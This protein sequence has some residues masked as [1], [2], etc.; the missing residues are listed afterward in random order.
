MFLSKYTT[1][2]A[3]ATDEQIREIKRLFRKSMHGVV[4]ASMREKGMAYRVNF[5]LTLPLIKRIASSITPNEI[6]AERLWKEHVRES[7]MLA[8]WLYPPQK[9]DMSTAKRWIDETPY[10]EIADV[11]CMN[12]FPYIDD[13]P[14]QATDCIASSTDMTRYKGNQH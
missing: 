14:Q 9:M 13:A 4:A 7:K 5:G 3:T 1:M 2:S 12:L 8:T 11:C 6:L 10:T